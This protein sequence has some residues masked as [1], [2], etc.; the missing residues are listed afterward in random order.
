MNSDTATFP[1]VAL[2]GHRELP[3][4]DH[5]RSELT[6]VAARLRDEH[7]TRIAISGMALGAD[8][9]WAQAGEAAG[10]ELHAFIPFEEQAAKWS[11]ADQKEWRRLRKLAARRVVIGELDAGYPLASYYH[12]RNEAMVNSCDLLIA[13]LDLTATRRRGGSWATVTKEQRW[14]SKRRPLLVVDAA[15][16]QPT[17][18]LRPGYDLAG[19]TTRT[20]AHTGRP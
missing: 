10:L 6:R 15:G 18:L 9:L 20:G 3:D 12:A 11:E 2:T 17:R 16:T 1:A 4:E 5:V 19:E 8:T 13:V 14:N 7:G